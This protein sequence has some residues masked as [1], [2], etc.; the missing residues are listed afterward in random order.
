M[1]TFNLAF[2]YQNNQWEIT[3]N[4]ALAPPPTVSPG[5][6]IVYSSPDADVYLQFP[7]NNLFDELSDYTTTV[8][9]GRP[10]ELTAKA[11]SVSA[12]TQLTYSAFCTNAPD[13]EGY[14]VGGSPPII[15]I[16]PS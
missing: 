9:K 5:D 12:E 1:A 2:T 15:V 8:S 4:G 11:N 14:A 6:V 13:P 7:Q 10:I 3:Q 16:K